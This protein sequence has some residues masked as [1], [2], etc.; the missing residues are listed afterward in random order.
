MDFLKKHSKTIMAIIIVVLIAALIRLTFFKKEPV[1]EIVTVPEVSRQTLRQYFPQETKATINDMAHQIQRAKNTQAPQYHYYT[2]TQEYADNKAQEYGKAQKA[3]KIVKET[4]EV[5]VKDDNGN[6]TSVI[7][8][9]YYAINLE[10]KHRIKAGAMNVDGDT[11]IK[12]A[13]QNRDV[14]YEVYHSPKTGKTG[15]GLEVTIAK[16]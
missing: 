7:E 10:R 1:P 6:K 2:V 14:E 4:H 5:E 3:D 9:D 13:Y 15:V 12:A 8:N 16:W 11:Y